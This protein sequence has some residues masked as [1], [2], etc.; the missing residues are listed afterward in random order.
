MRV[1]CSKQ[2]TPVLDVIL[3]PTVISIRVVGFANVNPMLTIQTTLQSREQVLH[4]T[5][6]II[7]L[8]PQRNGFVRYFVHYDYDYEFPDN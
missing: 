3:T 4:L 1:R 7:Y 8:I 6:C 5:R 2:S